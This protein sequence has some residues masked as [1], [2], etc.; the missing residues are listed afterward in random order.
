MRQLKTSAGD[1]NIPVEITKNREH[2]GRYADALESCIR[3]DYSPEEFLERCETEALPVTDVTLHKKL[4]GKLQQLDAS[5]QNGI[6]ARIIKNAFAPLF[7]GKVGYVAG[8]P[9]WVNWEHL[10]EDYR[11]AMKPLWEEYNLFT[12]SG[13]EGRLGGGKKDISMLFTYSS[14]DNYLEEGG[15]LGFVITQSVFKTQGAG[16]GFRRFR[17]NRTKP[18]KTTWRLKPLIVHDLSAM[19]VFEGATNR[20]AVFVCEKT[21]RSF[22]YPVEYTTWAGPSR[23]A[24]DESLASVR[25]AT[26]QHKMGAIPV[27]ASKDSSPWLTA[28]TTARSGIRKVVGSSDYRAYAGCCTWLNGV[29]WVNII[30]VLSDGKLL[31]EN[32]YDVGKIKVRQEQSAI[33]PDLVYPL[34]RGR[35]VQRWQA[36]PSTHI[37][38]TQDP[39]TR[40]GIP[41]A[42]MKRC[43]P[44]TYA[45]LKRFEEKLRDRAGFKKFF[46]STAPFYSI[47]NV[48]PYTIAEWKV[49]W[50]EQSSSFQAAFAGFKSQQVIVPDHKL[51][52]VPCISEQEAHFLLGMLNSS[53]SVLAVHSYAIPTS[54][55]TH[56]LNNVAIPRFTKTDLNHTR[57]AELSRQCHV[58]AK[59]S[60][61]NRLT[62]LEAEIDEVA[63]KIWGITDAELKAIR[64]ALPEK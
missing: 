4:Y 13:S 32:L 11:D 36:T 46:N 64:E 42:E 2:I 43:W 29:Y 6:W 10:P 49:V 35:D 26:T 53:P 39:K 48:G 44:N 20:T 58:A 56:V 47:Y 7:I 24:Q 18:Q 5:N 59:Q 57:L 8:N 51:M 14:V 34:L 41:E 40:K 54:T 30:D 50:R 3:A 61:E 16:D 21:T 27:V 33:E 45:Y 12:L 22:K 52:L 28:P 17:Y 62:R 60:R 19:Q 38:L 55:S 23:I 63:A 1:F 15:K 25:T 9:P 31:I 37:I